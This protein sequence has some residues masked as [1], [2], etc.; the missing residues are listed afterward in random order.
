MKDSKDQEFKE[1]N[2][3]SQALYGG[4]NILKELG[5]TFTYDGKIV[6][7]IT[8]GAD[9]TN[10]GEAD[11]SKICKD[12]L[13]KTE[14]KGAYIAWAFK[15]NYAGDLKG[16]YRVLNCSRQTYLD[17]PSCHCSINGKFLRIY[18]VNIRNSHQ[19]P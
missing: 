8:V 16:D 2:S 6:S 10:S 3:A 4:S 1:C 9:K 17:N 18:A 15:V 5:Q 14:S 19:K 11:P 12:L 13:D 7:T